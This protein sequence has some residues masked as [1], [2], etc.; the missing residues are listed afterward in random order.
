MV[1]SL[2]YRTT[3]QTIYPFENNASA[4]LHLLSFDDLSTASV[5]FNVADERNQNLS[6]A[7][8]E[9]LLSHKFCSHANMQ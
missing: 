1:K 9:L 6:E 3:I 8:K 2:K 4:N 5:H 7:Q